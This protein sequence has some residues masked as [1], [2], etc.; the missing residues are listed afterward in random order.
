MAILIKASMSLSLSAGSTC[1][2]F[3][4][5]LESFCGLERLL[6]KSI[7]SATLTP[8]TSAIFMRLDKVGLAACR[9]MSRMSVSD[10][11]VQ[12]ASRSCDMPACFLWFLI[13]MARC[14]SGLDRVFVIF[15]TYPTWRHQKTDIK[16][17]FCKEK[18]SF[19]I[20]MSIK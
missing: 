18:I 5:A 17:Y 10:R 16:T 7:N 19:N 3:R 2:S 15:A 12:A 14:A 11:P 8:K 1:S 13:Y 20:F 4:M 6:L 9:S